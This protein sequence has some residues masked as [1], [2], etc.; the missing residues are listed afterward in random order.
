MTRPVQPATAPRIAARIA[1]ATL[2][3]ILLATGAFAQTAPPTRGPAANGSPAWFM[4]GSFPDPGGRTSVDANGVVTVL[5]RPEGAPFAA[6]ARPAAVQGC[7]HTTV[8]QNRNGPKRGDM[9]RVQ[10]EQ[11]LG[12]R[13]TYPIQLP[14][15]IGG[16]PAVALDS[17]DNLWVFQ[18]KPAGSAQLLR[19]SSAGKLTR[20]I[21]DDVVGHADKAH[22]MAIDADDNIWVLDTANATAKKVSPDGRL[23][24]TIGVS[25]QPGDWDEAKG[26]RLLWEPVMIAFGPKGDIYIAQGHGNESP[27]VVDS[28]NPTNNIGAS[29]VLHLDRNGNYIGQWFGHNVGE[30]KFVN[31]HALGIDPANGDVW[32][33]D[34]E[35]YRIVVYNSRGQFLRTMQTR[36]LVCAIQFD[37]DGNPWMASGQDGQFLKLTRDGKVVGAVGNGMGIGPGQFIEASYWVFDKQNNMW[38]GDTSVG[39]VTRIAK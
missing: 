19:Y 28:D 26:Q 16:V 6:G 32:V 20:S 24:Q 21:G 12:Y 37:R 2:G 5:P 31:A 33:G 7:S 29:R 9:Q 36:N 39:R 38:A 14:A 35:D 27:N 11:K 4:Q 10:W 8:C 22:G 17:K 23:L 18:R 34:R 1:G 3:A 25:G 15:G 30:G 13:F